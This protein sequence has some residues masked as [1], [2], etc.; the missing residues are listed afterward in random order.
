[1]NLHV[2]DRKDENNVSMRE[3]MVTLN[4]RARGSQRFGGRD[5]TTSNRGCSSPATPLGTL[6][7][8]LNP[9]TLLLPSCDRIMG[10]APATRWKGSRFR[11]VIFVHIHMKVRDIYRV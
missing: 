9:P 1:M 7:Q 5:C 11:H 2:M 6:D 10:G 3:R 8:G 4:I